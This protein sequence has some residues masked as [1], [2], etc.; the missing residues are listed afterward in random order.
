[1]R[2]GIHDHVCLQLCLH[3]A[4]TGVSGLLLRPGAPCPTSASRLPPLILGDSAGRPP[5]CGRPALAPCHS[6]ASSVSPGC[7]LGVGGEEGVFLY[8]CV[9]QVLATGL[10]R[11]LIVIT[12]AW[13]P[14]QARVGAAPS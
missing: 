6:A 11:T 5:L 8:D 13:L 10:P 4:A 9:T 1:M 3:D 12:W 7:C 14:G 2:T